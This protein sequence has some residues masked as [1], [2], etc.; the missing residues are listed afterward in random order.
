[1]R[2]I[3]AKSG[4]EIVELRVGYYQA[5]YFDFF[6]PLYLLNAAYELIAS[7]LRLENLGAN[8]LIVARRR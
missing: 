2:K 4:F 6:V 1:M 7:S 3:V 5:E 8:M